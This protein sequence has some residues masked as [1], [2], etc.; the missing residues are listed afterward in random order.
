MSYMDVNTLQMPLESVADYLEMRERFL[1]RVMFE[2][3][4]RVKCSIR[5]ENDGFREVD[6]DFY[7]ERYSS[8]WS[9]IDSGM[10]LSQWIDNY[11]EKNFELNMLMSDCEVELK[12]RDIKITYMYQY[13]QIVQFGSM[14]EFN[15][16][17]N[18]LLGFKRFT[19]H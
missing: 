2:Y 19:Y 13:P 3:H 18:S 9:S 11:A 5:I 10:T 1:Q 8:A 6:V 17:W 14:E 15:E 16:H 7:H 12:N 4:S